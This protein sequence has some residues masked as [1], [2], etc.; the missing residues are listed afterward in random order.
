MSMD[1][2]TLKEQQ[3]RAKPQLQ[4]VPRAFVEQVAERLS[5]GAQQRGEFNWRT[6]AMLSAS[7]YVGKA[8][9][10]LHA[11]A[12]G[13]INDAEGG[14]H[15][16]AAAADIAIMLD[17][18][19]HARLQ[20]DLPGHGVQVPASEQ[21]VLREHCVWYNDDT[22]EW[23]ADEANSNCAALPDLSCSWMFVGAVKALD[24]AEAVVTAKRTHPRLP[25]GPMR[26][27]HT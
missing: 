12:D 19:A 3:E 16:A 15:L 7:V 2:K 14:S 23:Y 22:Q 26:S 10:H 21:A 25:A 1:T 13:E 9:R 4:L 6:G 24:A 20:I 8:L 18:A 27:M 5:L 17:A 11:Y